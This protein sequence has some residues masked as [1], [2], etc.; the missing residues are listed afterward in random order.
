MARKLNLMIITEIPLWSIGARTGGPALSQ[1]VFGW[2]RAGHTVHLITPRRPYV[3]QADLPEGVVLHTFKHTFR[4]IALGLR[5]I[6]WLFDSA[7]WLV[8]QRKARRIGRGLLAEQTFHAVCGY[9]VWGIPVARKLADEAKLPMYSRFQGTRM[10]RWVDARFG[11]IRF[12]KYFKAFRTPADLYIMTDDGSHG[13]EL[14][15]KFGVDPEK[16]RHWRNGVEIACPPETDQVELKG[17][18]GVEATGWMLLTLC[19][20]VPEKGVQH[21]VRAMPAVLERFPDTKLVVVGEGAYRPTLEALAIELGVTDAV[22]FTGGLD[23]DGVAKAI[24]AAD[25]FISPHEDTN[26]GNQ[27]LEAMTCGKPIVAFDVGGTS[28]IVTDGVNGVMLPMNRPERLADVVCDLLGDNTR[29]ITLG[30]GAHDWA[31]R[32]LRTWKRRIDMEIAE[33][34]RLAEELGPPG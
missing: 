13:D 30:L 21:A 9:D 2:A 18:F 34:T 4:G 27:V 15:A 16:I 11:N 29:R 10:D 24:G 17:G 14:L 22:V 31:V 25:I 3:S 28:N 32:N 19:R 12:F 1:T 26:A 8:F 20:L 33:V 23:R 6:G 5:K 7:S